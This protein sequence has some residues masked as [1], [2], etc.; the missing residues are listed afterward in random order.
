[1][2]QRNIANIARS[3]AMAQFSSTEQ[4][5]QRLVVVRGSSWLL[6]VMAVLF[7][8]FTLI[9]GFF[10]K[11]PQTIDG[12]GII[13]PRNTRPVEVMSASAYGGVV[14][15]IVPEFEDVEAGDPIVRLHNEDLKI[16]LA[17]AKRHLSDLQ[18]QDRKLTASEDQILAKRKSSRDEQIAMSKTIIEQTNELVKMIKQEVKDIEMLVKDRLVPRSQLV[19]TR[20]SL[21]TSMQQIVQQQT[22]ESQVNIEYESLVNTTEQARLDRMQAIASAEDEVKAAE[23]KI[24]TSTIVH[25]PIKGRVL[26]HAVDLGSALQAGTLV[27]SIRPHGESKDE[28]IEVIAYVPFSLGKQVRTDMDVEVSLSYAKPTRYGY[29]KGK[30]DR[31]GEF[32]AGATTGIH[33]GSSDL[34]ES[35]AKSLG[36]ML[37]VVVRMERDPDTATGLAWTSGKG[38]TKPIEFPSLCGVRVITGQDRPI[39]LVLPWLKNALGL[40]PE[41][42]VL[43]NGVGSE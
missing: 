4:L 33:L 2:S 37:E 30:V 40:D 25:A 15:L 8:T 17:N 27:T 10:G 29:I 16:S 42:S 5:D 36:P 1:M 41:P 28:L 38:Y 22:Q 7:I 20:S 19:S 3:E 21:Y 35:M 13:V 24:A 39:Q 23:T 26:E 6:L 31:V 14:E 18:D 32:V 43:T 34:A 12:E 9:W 11:V